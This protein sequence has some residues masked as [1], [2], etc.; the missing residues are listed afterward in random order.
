MNLAGEKEEGKQAEESKVASAG[1][2]RGRMR[3]V[4]GQKQKKTITRDY[5]GTFQGLGRG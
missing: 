1:V 5:L 2:G 3:K 4:N